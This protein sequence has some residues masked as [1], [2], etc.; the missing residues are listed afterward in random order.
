MKIQYYT[1]ALE[2]YRNVRQMTRE[3]LSE[4]SGLSMSSI[5]RL[6]NETINLPPYDT[7]TSV[8]ETTAEKVAVITNCLEIPQYKIWAS[9]PR[10]YLFMGIPIESSNDLFEAI[11]QPNRS[12]NKFIVKTLP[13]KLSHKEALLEIATKIDSAVDV[14]ALSS[15]DT[16][17]AQIS[18]NNAFVI[19]S[20]NTSG[21]FF[22]ILISQFDAAIFEERLSW[23]PE[24]ANLSW[25]ESI[26]ICYSADIGKDKTPFVRCDP[27]TH[28][29]ETSLRRDFFEDK[30]QELLKS[31]RNNEV[32]DP[33]F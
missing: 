7:R 15:T 22:K 21:G 3:R 33:P 13:Q 27:I 14:T 25:L 32:V 4:C 5:N 30:Q 20:E 8:G 17:Q 29:D 2:G 23:E 19:L 1:W 10:D 28:L 11:S 31:G 6:E 24:A 16:L 18:I 12:L 26:S 9:I